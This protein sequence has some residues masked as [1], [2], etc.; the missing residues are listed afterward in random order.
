MTFTEPSTDALQTYGDGLLASTVSDW[1]VV[2]AR[3][4]GDVI[5]QSTYAVDALPEDAATSTR[6]NIPALGDLSGLAWLRL[7]GNPVFEAAPLGRLTLLRWVWLAAVVAVAPVGAGDRVAAPAQDAAPAR[8][9]IVVFLS[10]DVGWG[11]PGFNGGTEVDTPNMDRIAREGVKLTQFYVQP[12][13]S[14][15][16]AALL[17][18]R[19]PWKNGMEQ[20][21]GY[22]ASQ[23]M[24]LDERT[25]A[26]ALRDAGYA[27]WIV[28]KWHLGHW[29]DGHLP[30]Q[31]G[32][33]HHY[34]LYTAAI[35]SFTHHRGGILDWHRNGRPVV[36][37]G[38]STFLLADEAAALVG[39]HDGS[40]PF[41]L[42]LPFNA[43][44]NPN[45]APEAYVERY[46]HLEH[47]RQRAQFKAMDVAIG[48]VMAALDRRGVLDDT[49]VMF[50]N[51]NG[52]VDSAG[53]NEPWRGKKSS[54][55][56][57]GIRVPAVLRWP[58]RIPPGTESAALLHA[59]DLFPTFAG[60][61]GASTEGGQPL[62]GV[63][64]WQAIAAGAAS[65]RE[66]VVH[67]LKVIR[68]GDWKLI[69]RDGAYY[70]GRS[71]PLQLYDIG[72]D[73]Y[74]GTNRAAGEPAKIAELRARLAHHRSFV[75]AGEANAT[76]PGGRPVVYGA[77]ENAT[78]GAEVRRS[79]RLRRA[80]NSVPS[81]VRLAVDG[82]R[83]RLVYDETLNA[84]SVP[85]ADAFT[86]VLN[87][88][89]RVVAVTGVGLNGREVALTLARPVAPGESVG[90]TYD[91]PPTG[92]VRDADGL[93]A[94]GLTWATAAAPADDAPR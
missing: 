82:A 22:W 42:Y 87:P 90:L 80:G 76:I 43:A 23:G 84:A 14:P 81:L 77:T 72:A 92:A 68:V 62:D 7:A 41:F 75:R 8:P 13:C 26:E 35:D 9:N 69:E 20:R 19:Y 12:R 31:R 33:E 44:H 29:R 24:L 60:L 64:A 88:G 36:E 79:R 30:R 25:L 91:V 71:D 10:D 61:A 54:Y 73:P 4:G 55:Y 18:G 6:T 59:V 37:A 49:L 47:P 94:V 39:R 67:S 21:P 48:Q 15:T 50:L 3:D 38:Y 93:A 86:V 51:D 65:P 28:G 1:P 85:S 83:V 66:E 34:G 78:F 56:E 57:G 27:T 89:Y 52:G 5:C 63:D 70:D 45:D 53:W 32:F 74:E 58:R 46:A 40:R 11:Q 16:R 2:N 17:T